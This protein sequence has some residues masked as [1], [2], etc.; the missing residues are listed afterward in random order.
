[1]IAL[2]I[3]TKMLQEKNEWI[4]RLAKF[5]SKGEHEKAEQIRKDFILSEADRAEERGQIWIADVLR[6]RAEREDI[7]FRRECHACRL[8]FEPA[9]QN[10]VY[11][12]DSCREDGQITRIRKRAAKNA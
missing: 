9:G 11:C 12:S 4:N 3:W 8:Y 10:D 6:R 7:V 1:M 5:R 2:H